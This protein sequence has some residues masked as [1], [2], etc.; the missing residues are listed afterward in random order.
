MEENCITIDTIMSFDTVG[1]KQYLL[2]AKTGIAIIPGETSSI[3]NIY[4][5]D[6]DG[7]P[8]EVK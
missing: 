3:R 1:K 8:I 5:Y 2:Q 4:T 7:K 6:K